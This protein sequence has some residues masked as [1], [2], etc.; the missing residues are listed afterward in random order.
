MTQ[1]AQARQAGEKFFISY[2]AA[3]LTRVEAILALGVVGIVFLLVLPIPPVIMDI[4]I[5]VNLF[6]GGMLIV[7]SL[8]VKGLTSFTTFP[9]VLL[10]STLFRLGIEV[11]TSRMILMEADAGAIV[12]TFGNF[13]VGGNLV[14]GLVVFIIVMVVQFIVITKGGE[15]I[16]EVSARFSLDAMPA[17][18]LAIESELRTGLIDSTRAKYLRA[19]LDVETQLLGSMD[20]AMK[21]VKGDSIAGLIIVFVNLLGG[22]GVGVMMR[23][24]SAGEAMHVYSVL[25]IGDGL[26]AQ[27]PA[28]LTS[29]TAAILVSRINEP[30]RD[31]KPVSFGAELVRQMSEHPRALWTVSIVMAGFAMIPG[32][33]TIAFVTLSAMAAGVA[34]WVS[35]PKPVV[36]KPVEQ[37]TGKPG[38]P[39]VVHEFNQMEALQFALPSHA[40]A[41][42]DTA[43]VVA[44]VH[45]ARNKLV[46]ELGMTLPGVNIKYDPNLPSDMVEFRVYEVPVFRTSLRS[47]YIGFTGKL[48]DDLAERP[49]AV[50][51]AGA[52]IGGGNIVWL[53]AASLADDPH[54]A[55]NGT[56]WPAF[57]EDRILQK[58]LRY[59]PRFTGVQAAQKYITWMESWMA[60]LASEV[61]KAVPM[62]K[63][64]EVIQRLLKERV[65]IRNMRLIMETLADHGTR[66]RDPAALAEFVRFALREQICHQ[67]APLGK[68]AVFV[69]SPEL[70]EH[71]STNVR[72]NANGSFL[73]LSPHETNQISSAIRAVVAQRDVQGDTPVLVCAQDVRR[74]VRTLLE[75][76][77]PE[78]VVMSVTELTPEISVN[79]AASI[80][81]PGSEQY[82]DEDGYDD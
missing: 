9:V 11:S 54:L 7:M 68:L 77:L 1:I 39:V 38:E 70:E 65:S 19:Q 82:D 37:S 75:P 44:G 41:L 64:A 49:D 66:E 50:I 18:Q 71:I 45:N 12:D 6:I 69:L 31:G 62:S 22:L 15:R 5:A 14:V 58:C 25:T 48:A 4:L 27:I 23:G 17:K 46:I 2:L 32:M 3:I 79:V 35:R 81:M 42:A 34:W 40:P 33:P 74:H 51:D 61:K 47:E 52:G 26:V 30:D 43:K 72:Q 76:D 13:V 53:P 29:L 57:I 56:A 10:L 63:L 24:L 80:E 28:L 59:G 36:Q 21:F 73:S 55:S 67:L 20:G 60:E 8:Y 78:M 16:S